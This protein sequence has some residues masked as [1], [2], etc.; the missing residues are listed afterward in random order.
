MTTAKYNFKDLTVTLGGV[1]FDALA[2]DV[3][4]TVN[5][6]D[7]TATGHFRISRSE[8]RKLVALVQGRRPRASRGWRKHIRR[9]KAAERRVG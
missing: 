7:L 6:A 9:M 5:R 4:A 3:S 2:G 1:S 8:H